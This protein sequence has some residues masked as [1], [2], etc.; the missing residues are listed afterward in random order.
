MSPDF[1]QDNFDAAAAVDRFRDVN[2]QRDAMT[3]VEGRAEFD[4]IAMRLRAE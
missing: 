2:G 3:T 4:S 1:A